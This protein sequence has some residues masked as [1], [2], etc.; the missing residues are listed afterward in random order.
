MKWLVIA[1]L[2]A[3]APRA[4]AGDD[5]T[6][7][8]RVKQGDNLELIAAEFYG[9]HQHTMIFIMV[10]NKL[11]HPRKLNPGERLKIPTNRELTTAKGDSFESI[12][13]TYLGDPRRA[14]FLA[15]FNHMSPE[16][17]LATGT[18]LVIPFHVTHTAAGPETLKQISLAYFGDD[19][20][21]EMLRT[22]N[23][24]GDKTTLDKND[25]I[26]VPS[27][28]VRVRAE[29]LP[30]IDADSSKRREAQKQATTA[31]LAALPTAHTAWLRGDF[32]VVR[33]TLAPLASKLDYLDTDRSI[34]VGLLLGRAHVAFDDTPSAV[35][36]FAQVLNRQPRHELSAYRESPKILDAWRQA[37]GHVQGE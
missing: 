14:T 29:R 30:Q 26:I 18:T 2:V 19:K 20:Q 31:A 5:D 22:Y 1:A 23:N 35:A 4:H 37:G 24:L 21:A 15:E 3:F 28:H 32:A 25:S 11:Q 6:Q 7:N 17:S 10:E 8:Y 12:A 13:Q 16:D 34:E 33:Q 36:V 9:D 27:F